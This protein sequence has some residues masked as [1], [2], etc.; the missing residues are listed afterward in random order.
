M[1]LN[2]K[3]NK[4]LINFLDFN[5]QEIDTLPS[6]SLEIPALQ[7]THDSRN[8]IMLPSALERGADNK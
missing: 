8:Q 6:F 2:N 7:F 5:H 4:N 1:R 3:C